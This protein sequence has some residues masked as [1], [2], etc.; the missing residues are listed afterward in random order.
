MQKTDI[1]MQC[2]FEVQNVFVKR[3]K[4]KVWRLVCRLSSFVNLRSSVFGFQ[5]LCTAIFR[6]LYDNDLVEEDAFFKW[7][8]DLKDTSEGKQEAIMDTFQWL[9]WLEEAEV[10][11]GPYM[12]LIHAS[13]LMLGFS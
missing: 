6:T 11:F 8:D 9:K 12:S 3:G 2:L 4:T 7:K 13:S 5:G 1:Q 10:S